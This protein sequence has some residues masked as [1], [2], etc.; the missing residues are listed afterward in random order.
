MASPF[1]SRLPSISC[2]LTLIAE[3]RTGLVT[4]F[5]VFKFMAIYSLIQFTSVIILYIIGKNLTDFEFLFIDLCLVTPLSITMG[6]TG[7]AK[8]LSIER[9][10]TSLFSLLPI[11]S[12]LGNL[13][14]NVCFQLL[15]F[16][17]T[18]MQPWFP[19]LFSFSLH[20]IYFIRTIY[21][22]ENQIEEPTSSFRH[23]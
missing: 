2:V 6:R 14:I 3:G 12:I 7:A 13:A 8:T 19:F 5:C 21:K 17:Y 18:Q 4:S 22:S 10:L 9:P 1:T 16:T 20:S 11:L 23:N 15:I